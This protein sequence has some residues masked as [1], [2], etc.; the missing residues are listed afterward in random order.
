MNNSQVRDNGTGLLLRN[1]GVIHSYGNNVIGG[2]VTDGA[3]TDTLP[4]Q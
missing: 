1:S 2:N 3:P 4:R